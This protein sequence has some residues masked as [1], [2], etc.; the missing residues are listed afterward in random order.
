MGIEQLDGSADLAAAR[1]ALEGHRWQEA[2]DLLIRADREGRLGASDLQTLAQVAWFT[3]Q[4]DLAVEARERA[5]KAYIVDGNKA[6]AAAIAFE[7][8]R[9]YHNKRK[10]S[11][12]SA[13]A[14]RGE[15]APTR[16]ST[17]WRRPP[18]PP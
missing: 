11:I 14:A 10:F 12:A 7:L 17:S 1:D 16:D 6:R 13:W 4:P 2:L 5:F 8:S 18:S 3:A 9:E 15:D